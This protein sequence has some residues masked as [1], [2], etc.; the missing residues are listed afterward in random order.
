MEEV[1]ESTEDNKESLYF[2]LLTQNSSGKSNMRFLAN[3]ENV[4]DE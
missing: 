1:Y 4:E 3:L 2:V